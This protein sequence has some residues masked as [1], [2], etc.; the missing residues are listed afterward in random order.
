MSDGGERKNF[1]P[2]IIT[3]SG[4]KKKKETEEELEEGEG[5]NSGQ[6]D[7]RRILFRK[8]DNNTATSQE[9]EDISCV[10]VS[11][12]CYKRQLALSKRHMATLYYGE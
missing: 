7:L 12:K 8:S 1:L 3:F 10:N 11:G 4:S 6:F 5:S 9:R 2:S